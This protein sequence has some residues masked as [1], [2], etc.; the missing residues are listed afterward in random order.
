MRKSLYIFLVSAVAAV[1]HITTGCLSF[2]GSPESGMTVTSIG[3]EN[4]GADY[5]HHSGSDSSNTIDYG[6]FTVPQGITI[7]EIPQAFSGRCQTTSSP[8]LS[9]HQT[10]FLKAGR[11][12]SPQA[13]LHFSSEAGIM[14]SGHTSFSHHLISLRKIRC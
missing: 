4:N 8:R 3:S 6:T 12:V 13:A 14:P 11:I 9:G 7:P 5:L 10:A 2:P 1:V